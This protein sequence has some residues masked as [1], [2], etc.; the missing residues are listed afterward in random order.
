MACHHISCQWILCDRKN[1]NG[2]IRRGLDLLVKWFTDHLNEGMNGS[3]SRWLSGVDGSRLQL[4]SEQFHLTDT[5]LL[6]QTTPPRNHV[7]LYSS[8]RF[9]TPV[10]TQIKYN[11]VQQSIYEICDDCIHKT[12]QFNIT[13]KSKTRPKHFKGL[14]IN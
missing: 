6:H 3:T 1:F 4:V 2:M 12:K 5:S 10:H 7:H 11:T 13:W 14:Y 8:P 9:Q